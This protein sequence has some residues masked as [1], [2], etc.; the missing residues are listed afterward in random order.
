MR[1]IK[2]KEQCK[3][4]E[5]LSAARK[6]LKDNSI[7]QVLEKLQRC[8]RCLQTIEGNTF[9]QLNIKPFKPIKPL[10]EDADDRL[11]CFYN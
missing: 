6:I 4:N 8:K 2:N 9:K 7:P 11:F 3:L 1:F 10:E 5:N